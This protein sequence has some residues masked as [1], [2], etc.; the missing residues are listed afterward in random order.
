MPGR[1]RPP[2]SLRRGG[3]WLRRA[4]FG[5]LLLV[6][7]LAGG[8]AGVLWRTL[9]PAEAALRLPGLS[10]AVAV[11][12]D[13]HAIPHI[14]AATEEDAAM[15]L[16]WLH[17]R[18]RMFQ[19]ELMR[20]SGAGRLAEIAGPAALRADRMARTLGLARRA[21][22][23]LLAL[24]ADTRRILDAYARGVNAWI[25]ARGRFAAPEFLALGPPERW[26]PEHSLLWAKIM[27]VWLS[28]NWRLE[29]DR[30]RLAG[31]LPPERLAELWP[32]DT[33]A[34]DPAGLPERDAPEGPARGAALAP[35][36]DAAPA[37]GG[38]APAAEAPL[39]PSGHPALDPA[40]LGRLAAA[41]PAFPERFTLPG[42]ASNAWAVAGG[43]SATGRP[44]LAS[45]PHLGFQAP[46]L[47]YLVRIDLA[48]GRLLAGATSPGVPFLVIGRNRDLAW[49][50]T[51]T[52]SDTQD[53]F[54]ERLAGTAAYQTP[55]GP[56]P[57]TVTDERIAVRG[58]PEEWLRVRETRHGPV[59][60]DLDGVAPEGE[61]LAVAMANLAPADTAAA[62]LLAL[63]RA[64]SLA[65]ARAA[66]QRITSPPQNL[67][68]ADAAGRIGMYLTGRVPLRRSG[69]GTQPA[70]GWDGSQDWLGFAAFGDLPHVEDPA[71][72][73]LANA[74]N[75]VAPA[76]GP[77]FLGRDW[78]AD[79]R[80]RRIGALLAARPR[81]TAE[82][83]IAMQGDTRSG[84]AAAVVLAPDVLIRH[85][86]RPP[87]MAGLAFDLL[88]GWDGVVAADRPQP[89]IFNA[90]IRHFGER[91]LA[92]GGV[93]AGAW[94]ARSEFL[95]GLLGPAGARSPWCGGDCP[96]LIAA[97]FE[98]AMAE[99]AAAFGP[100][101]AAWRWGA[102]HVARFEHPLLRALPGLA[103]LTRLAAA[104]GGDEW[105][106]SR[107]GIQGAGPEPFAHVHGAGLRLVADLADADRTFASIA[108]G[109][110]GNPLSPHWGDLLPGWRD[111]RPVALARTPAAVG[112]RIRLSP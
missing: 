4:G 82:D 1:K 76:D 103:G 98:A 37:P 101:P 40:R 27:G 2:R 108:T 93:P 32:E 66:A 112:G 86:P 26:E 28:G 61:V 35:G 92:R 102:V 106:V 89:L 100:D 48:D 91:A 107:G 8:L 52:Q 43:R 49:G 50:F 14:A 110:S 84:F 65:E 5:L 60:S 67:L 55:Q 41:L 71:S 16:G 58:R 23:D 88:L 10:A 63:N 80:F 99:L 79:W 22:A 13:D 21:R 42:S 51:T 53:V 81:H 75:R 78:F 9:P 73:A 64:A 39:R 18:D 77:V 83:F 111:F 59:I 57:F 33:S 87:G 72:G 6:L 56:R 94:A 74:N 19:M 97:S 7:L 44:L 20:R 12:L 47:W 85:I 95:A 30:A 69:D 11:T 29:L 34:G 38:G 68:V 109:Q 24:P 46:I 62:G 54:V 17:A 15:A 3:R 96:A 25:E 90:W 105:T 70:R 36:G 45:D 104:T 31:V